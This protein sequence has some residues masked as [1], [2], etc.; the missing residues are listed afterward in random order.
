MKTQRITKSGAAIGSAVALLLISVLLTPSPALAKEGRVR[1][2]NSKL[3]S[4]DVEP[5]A[6]GHVRSSGDWLYYPPWL[7]LDGTV[8]GVCKGLTPGK[9]YTITVIQDWPRHL[10]GTVSAV[11]SETGDLMFT[12]GV[13][14]AD[15]PFPKMSL[16]YITVAND[17]GQIVLRG[18]VHFH[19]NH[20]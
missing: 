17:A 18:A 8:T 2:P 20:L 19:W 15:V 5:G 7:Y 13:W 4:T 1:D 14:S 10:A 11:A 16:F 12:C 6:S 3:V 9:T